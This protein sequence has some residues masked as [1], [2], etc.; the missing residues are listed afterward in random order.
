MD[1]EYDIEEPTSALDSDIDMGVEV[2]DDKDLDTTPDNVVDTVQRLRLSMLLNKAPLDKD[3]M[4]LMNDL[5]RT[6]QTQQRINVEN[7]QAESDSEIAKSLAE[8]VTSGI[9]L[10][11]SASNEKDITPPAMDTTELD[12]IEVKPELITTQQEEISLDEIMA[13][14]DLKSDN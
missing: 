11:Q 12:A 8:M 3:E 10:K 5:T 9:S 2:V 14:E 13:A 6:A 7:K 1:N 4:S